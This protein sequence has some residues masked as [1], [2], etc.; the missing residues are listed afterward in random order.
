M[1]NVSFAAHPLFSITQTRIIPPPPSPPLTSSVLLVG[2]RIT[3]KLQFS[4]SVVLV[5]VA[6]CAVFANCQSCYYPNGDPSKENDIPCSSSSGSACCPSGWKCLD[7]G[8]C[9]LDNQKYFGRYTCTDQSWKSPGCP[10]ICTHSKSLP[11]ATS[12]CAIV[13]RLRSVALTLGKAIRPL[14]MKRSCNAAKATTAVT[15]IAL[16]SDAAT[17]VP[18]NFN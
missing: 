8:L 18:L 5:V 9:Y 12:V 15:P 13:N 2:L 17:P 1:W 6:S 11:S 14:E 16:P 10:N 7:N 4:F 3:M